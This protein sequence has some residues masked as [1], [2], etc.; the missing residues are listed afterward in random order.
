MGADGAG[1]A[2][3]L[4]DAFD[5]GFGDERDD[6]RHAHADRDAGLGQRADSTQAAGRGRAC[7]IVREISKSSVVSVIGAQ[8]WPL[9]ATGA[10]RS[11]SCSISEGLVIMLIGC[12]HSLSNTSSTWRVRRYSRCYVRFFYCCHR[13]G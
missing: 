4:Q 10:S 8:A 2:R 11:M 12:W 7:S 9:E 1:V 3:H 6:R 5:F 13:K